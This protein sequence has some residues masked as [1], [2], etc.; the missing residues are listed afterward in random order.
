[1][2]SKVARKENVGHTAKDDVGAAGRDR[3]GGWGFAYGEDAKSLLSLWFT[4]E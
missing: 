4:E 1:M 3:S 2:A